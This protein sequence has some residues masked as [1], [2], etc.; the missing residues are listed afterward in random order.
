MFLLGKKKRDQESKWGEN[1][2]QVTKLYVRVK[3]QHFYVIYLKNV[4]DIK[5]PIKRQ[6]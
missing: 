4:N 2:R 1:R 3:P 5:A 6:R